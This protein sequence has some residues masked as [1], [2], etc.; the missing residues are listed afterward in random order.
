MIAGRAVTNVRMGRHPMILTRL[1]PHA[2]E[3]MAR[4]QTNTR[5]DQDGC[6]RLKPE[7]RPKP[8]ARPAHH[9]GAR[10]EADRHVG[11]GRAGSGEEAFVIGWHGIGLGQQS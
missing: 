8:F 6:E 9:P 1:K 4:F 5:I 10:I 11:A 3:D 2:A 7:R